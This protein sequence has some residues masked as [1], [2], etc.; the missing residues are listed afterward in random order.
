ME[1]TTAQILTLDL[2]SFQGAR[3]DR[4][5]SESALMADVLREVSQH[6]DAATGSS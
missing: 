6:A 5:A 1:P 4:H 3:S 2:V